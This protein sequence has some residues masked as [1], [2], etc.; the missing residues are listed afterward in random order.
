MQLLETLVH[1]VA[2]NIFEQSDFVWHI[3]EMISF[4]NITSNVASSFFDELW[5]FQL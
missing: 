5:K 4:T 3:V 1:K 2:S